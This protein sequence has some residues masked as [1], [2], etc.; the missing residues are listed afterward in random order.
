MPSYDRPPGPARSDRFVCRL[1][2]ILVVT[3]PF[4][5]CTGHARV[6][7]SFGEWR[8]G[9]GAPRDHAHDGVDVWGQ[10]DDPVLAAA[11]GKVWD[12]GEFPGRGSCGKY[13]E[14]RHDLTVEG[15][16]ATARTRYC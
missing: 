16:S 14:L 3:L 11:D 13:V 12:L 15:E 4:T 2:I 6:I 5:G 9:A 10:L 1:L 8:D 7:S